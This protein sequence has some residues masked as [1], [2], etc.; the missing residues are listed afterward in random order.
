MQLEELYDYKNK[1]MEDLL[2]NEEIVK[3][4]DPTISLEDAPS[5]A[6]SKVFPCEYVP[7][8]VE[9]GDTY[10]CFDV[11]VVSSPNKTFLFSAMY[12]WVFTHR[13]NLRLPEGGVRTDK[14]VSEICKAING[15]YE[16][17]LG[18][19]NLASVKRFAPMT[20]FQG[21]VMSFFPKEF[22]KQ[23]DPHRYIPSNRKGDKND[24]VDDKSSV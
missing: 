1:L 12:I 15:S 7:E 14:I 5:L 11:D 18:Q 13:S 9:H 8:T 19:L 16:Y 3:L 21:K 2:T 24:N 20:D 4:I 22:S 10:I 23:H 17:G 6:Y